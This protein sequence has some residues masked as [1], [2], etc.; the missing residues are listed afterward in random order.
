VKA[1]L[2]TCVVSEIGKKGG[3]SLVKSVVAEIATSNLFLSV[4]TVGEIAKGIALLKP[5]R[6]KKSLAFWL[7]T[8][9]NQFAD[10][11]LSIDVETARIWGELTGKAQ[12]K[13][14]VIPGIDGLIA[15]TAIRHGLHVFTRNVRHFDASGALVLNPWEDL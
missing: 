14:I 12:M 10:R 4:L 2:D 5:S 9:E 8:V 13:G 6:R 3:N 7:D 15:A 11:V 1:L